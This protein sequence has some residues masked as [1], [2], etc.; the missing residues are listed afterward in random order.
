MA[1]KTSNIPRLYLDNKRVEFWITRPAV[2]CS[3]VVTTAF[4]NWAQ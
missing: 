3:Y 1:E 2:E 4:Y